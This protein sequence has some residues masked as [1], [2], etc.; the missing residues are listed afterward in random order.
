VVNQIRERKGAAPVGPK[1]VQREAEERPRRTEIGISGAGGQGG[2]PDRGAS[3]VWREKMLEILT[4]LSAWRCRRLA[5][6]VRPKKG[7]MLSEIRQKASEI[8]HPLINSRRLPRSR[9]RA[10]VARKLFGVRTVWLRI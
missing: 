2:R 7:P 8:R 9:K 5:P 1:S 3:P 4:F 10:G 6:S